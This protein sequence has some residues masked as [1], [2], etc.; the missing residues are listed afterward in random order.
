M[1]HVGA[2]GS[3]IAF[4]YEVMRCRDLRAGDS[5]HDELCVADDY[6]IQIPTRWPNLSFALVHAVT[7]SISCTRF[8]VRWF[9]SR[10]DFS[11]V[12]CGCFIF[13]ELRITLFKFVRMYHE[14]FR[15]RSP[16]QH[17]VDGRN[18]P[19]NFIRPKF[20]IA[21]FAPDL[22]ATWTMLGL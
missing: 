22:M 1:D 5:T 16:P 6:L 3:P 15:F 21:R 9:I 20:H 18:D 11:A 8:E 12:S 4:N 10:T 14:R 2:V 13:V 17:V 19:N 7:W